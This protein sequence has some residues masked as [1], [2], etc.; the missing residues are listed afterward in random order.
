LK[1]N[2]EPVRLNPSLISSAS[3]EQAGPG[4]ERRWAAPNRR[5]RRRTM[6]GGRRRR[7][8]ALRR[9]LPPQSLG[10]VIAYAALSMGLVPGARSQALGLS[11]TS[12]ARW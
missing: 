6:A 1:V 12:L 11:N 7:V 8:P 3:A 10:V 4:E 9:R 5:P 2:L